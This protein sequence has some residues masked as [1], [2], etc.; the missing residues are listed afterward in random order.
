M[1]LDNETQNAIID[2][3]L[4]ERR[5]CKSEYIFVTAVG[6]AQKI[7]R[8]N[9]LIKYRA[10]SE[11]IPH[12]GLRVFRKTFAS[13]LLQS[14]TPLEMI[15]EMLGHVGKHSVQCYLSTDDMK[16]KRCAL[17]LS[18]IPCLRRDY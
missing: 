14:G 2:Y 17:N 8:R 15:S 4:N 3:I 12:D 5:D 9:F 6:A 13:K 10:S 11:K 16:M 18:L 7:A 1:P